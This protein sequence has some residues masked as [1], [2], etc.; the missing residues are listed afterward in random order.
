MTE[1]LRIATVAA[2]PFPWPRG[3]PIRI[4][5]IAE[6]MG[7]RGIDVHVVTYHLGEPLENASFTI[8]RIR[9]VPGYTRTAPGPT[10]RKLTQLDRMLAARLRNLHR[11]VRFHAVHAHHY[12]GLLAALLAR[13]GVPIVY[14][15]HTMLAGELPYYRTGIPPWLARKIGSAL[16]RRLPG[17]AA[18]T[19]AVSESIRSQLV[20]I[21]AVPPQ[22]TSVIANGVEWERFPAPRRDRAPGETLIFTG[23]LG[24]Y[25][26]IHFMV[27]AFAALLERRPGA[28]LSI[29]TES[30]FAPYEEEARRLDVRDRIDLTSAAFGDQPRLLSEADVALSPRIQCDG[31]PQKILNYMAAG[32]PIV[33]FEGSAVHLVHE[34]TA[35]RVPNEDVGAMAAAIERLLE[36]RALARRIGDNAREEARRVHSWDRTAERIEGVIRSVM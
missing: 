25:Q 4:H 16:D 3:T 36:D 31:I 17:R 22:R 14:D 18:H 7:R 28:R 26:G 33:A 10:V 11:D 2:C 9:D 27:R 1:R 30:S 12:E 35:L 32:V 23:N 20:A 24:P 34:A 8:H 29:V 19:I 15:A 13:A 21:G 5:R 6:A